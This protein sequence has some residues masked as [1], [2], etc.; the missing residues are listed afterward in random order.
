MGGR[1]GLLLGPGRACRGD[2]RAEQAARL[3][4]AAAAVREEIGRSFILHY[5]EKEVF[6]RGEARARA[7]L[8]PPA[9]AAAERSGTG[10]HPAAAMAEAMAL[11]DEIMRGEEG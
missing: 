10:T 9:F 1:C 8:G 4:G 6:D 2:G 3:F 7:A 5:P 11:V